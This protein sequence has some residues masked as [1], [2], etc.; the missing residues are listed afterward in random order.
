MPDVP[1]KYSSGTDPRVQTKSFSLDVGVVD[2]RDVTVEGHAG[3]S[4]G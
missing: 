1:V 4:N 3:F 2:Q